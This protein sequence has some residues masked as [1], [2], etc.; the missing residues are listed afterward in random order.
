MVKVTYLVSNNSVSDLLPVSRPCP[1]YIAYSAATTL[2]AVI[3][4]LTSGTDVVEQH[5]CAS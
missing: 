4:E 3:T 5:V 1:S 2:D